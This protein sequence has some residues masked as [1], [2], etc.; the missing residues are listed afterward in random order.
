MADGRAE[1]RFSPKPEHLN[2]FGVVHGGALMTL[3]DISMAGAA[4][5]DQP[6]SGVVT[7]E[8]KTTFMRPSRGPIVGRGRLMHRTL[9]MA[10]VEATVED[11]QGHVCCHATGTFKY[12]PRPV[13][14]AGAPT[15]TD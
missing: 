13:V 12:V 5:S 6:Q 14:P 11:A 2:S 9:S 7:I 15:P 3:L 10:F 1:L 4:R 8:M